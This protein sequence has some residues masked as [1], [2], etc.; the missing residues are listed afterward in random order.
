MALH[1][2]PLNEADHAAWLPLWQGYLRFYQT[3]LPDT[4]T[5]STW[6]RLLDPNEPMHAALGFENGQPVALVQW[7]FHRSTWMI[8]D[9]CYLQ[10]LF[11]REDQRRKGHAGRMIQH[12]ADQ[13]KAAGATRVHW[14]THESNHTAMR[15]YDRI[16]TRSGF[17]QYRKAV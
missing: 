17:V 13:A 11:V 8:E 16:A 10:D 9:S 2:Q 3:S 12:V 4:V 15:L 14:L 5:R 1:I 7:V 6:Q